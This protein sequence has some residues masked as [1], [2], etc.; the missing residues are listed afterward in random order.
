MFESWKSKFVCPLVWRVYPPKAIGC[1]HCNTIAT[2]LSSYND[3]FTSL[4][5]LIVNYIFSKIQKGKYI[6][7]GCKMHIQL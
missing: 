5:S 7:I 6:A 2:T 4:Q 1:F 3:A